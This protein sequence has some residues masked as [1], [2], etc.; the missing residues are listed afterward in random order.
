MSLYIL[1]TLA[2]R[3]LD[4]TKEK[5][6]DDDTVSALTKYIPTESITIFAA[7]VSAHGVMLAQW[8]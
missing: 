7:A 2:Q 4:T 6:P 8:P 3:D 1:A 5:N